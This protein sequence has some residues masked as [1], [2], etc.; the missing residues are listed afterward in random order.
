M[1]S[2]PISTIIKATTVQ[3][4][5]L[6]I[7]LSHYHTITFSML[8]ISTAFG[9]KK[10]GVG[11][12]PLPA[13]PGAQLQEITASAFFRSNRVEYDYDPR[14]DRKRKQKNTHIPVVYNI[15]PQ[16]KTKEFSVYIGRTRVYVYRAT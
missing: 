9:A 7:T 13:S 6:Y 16:K 1:R 15:T 4:G 12:M 11:N 8:D 3:D 5:V 14:S 2:Y 10:L